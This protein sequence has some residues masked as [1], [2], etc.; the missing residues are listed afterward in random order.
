MAL[1]LNVTP[2]FD[3]FDVNK[4]YLKILFKPGNSVQAREMTQLQSILQGQISNLSDH[5]FKEG[6]MVIPGQAALDLKANYAKVSLNGTLSTANGFVGKIVQGKSTGIRALVVNYSDEVDLNND[7]VIDGDNDE[8]TTLYLKYLDGTTSG[9]T[10]FSDGTTVNIL[11]G[12]TASFTVNGETV[13]ISEGQTSTF[14]EGEEL[15]ATTTD[16]VNLVCTV[17]TSSTVQNPIGIGSQ[18]FIEEGV[19]YINGNLVRVTSQSLILDKYSNT[20]SYKIGLEISESVVNYNDDPSLLDNSLG[21][22]NYNSPGADRYKVQLTLAKRDYDAIDTTNFVELIAVRNGFVS[23]YVSSTDYSVLMKTL[24]RRTYDE[25]G[26]YTVRPF[27]LDIREYFKENN[28][29][30]VYT[31]SDLVFETEVAAKDFALQNFPDDLGMVV[32]GEGQAHTISTID[33]TTYAEQT[34]DN[35][36]L[37]YYPGQTHENLLD[38]IRDKLAVGV[39]A[40]KAYV[41]GYE[42]ERKPSSNQSK[43][44]IFDKSRNNYQINNKYMPVNLGA[45]I[46]VTDTKGLFKIDESVNLVNVHSSQSGSNQ[47][48]NIDSNI[49][50]GEADYLHTITYNPTSVFFQGGGTTLGTNIYG[51]DV[52]ATAKVKAV[53]YFSESSDSARLNNYLQSN[54]RPTD[55]IEQSKESAIYK[56][57]LYDIEYELNPRTTQPYMMIDARSIVSETTVSNS[58]SDIYENAGNILTQLELTEAQG[59][60]TPKSLI[61]DRY[62]VNFRGINY[63]HN[64]ITNT[65]LIKPLNSGNIDAGA[66]GSG[67]LPSAS[68]T[69]NELIS[70]AIPS[71][72]TS[73]TNAASWNNSQTAD[74]GNVLARIF[75][76]SVLHNTS[77]SSLVDTGK[78]WVRTARNIN[79]LTGVSSIDTQYSVMKQ[80]NSV[81]FPAGTV[82]LIATEADTYFENIPSLYSIFSSAN[83]SDTSGLVGYIQNLAFSADLR[84]V[85]FDVTGT[86][87]ITSGFTALVPMKK[88]NAKEKTKTL[89]KNYI[90]LPL[91]LVGIEGSAINSANYDNTIGAVNETTS[92]YEADVLGINS[93]ASTGTVNPSF[94]V[95]ASGDVSM[96]LSNLQLQNADVRELIKLY[97][98]CNV[99]NV[100]YRTGVVSDNKKFIHEMTTADFDFAFKAYEFYEQ[101]GQS[102]FNVNL[103]NSVTTS[104]TELAV[105][106]VVDGIENPFNTEIINAWTNGNLITN[107]TEVPVKLNDIT[108]RYDLFDGQKPSIIQLG[109]LD[110]KPGSLPCG[111]RPIAIYSYYNHGVGDYA[112]V[113][114]YVDGYASI[115]YYGSERLSDV[116]DFR[117]VV[118]YVQTTGYP[119]GRGMV[120]SATDYPIDGTAVSADL[121][122]YLARKDKLFMDKLGRVRLKYGSPAENPSMPED[123]SEGMVL[124]ELESDP[125]TVGPKAIAT[126][127]RDNKRYTMRD[128][129]NLEKRI[130]NLE[131]Y[132]SLN[133]LEKDTMDLAVRDE[134]GNDRFKNGFIV[135]R[136]VDHTV[137]NVFD[138]DYKVSI[139]KTE[140]V[141]RSFFSEKLVNMTLDARSS[142][143]YAIKEQKIHLPYTSEYL[144][145]QEKSSKTV[146]VNPFAIFTFRGSISMF[147]STDEWKET[148][149]TPDIVT[150]RREQYDNIFGALS[151]EDG[152]MG[153]MWNGWEENW[154]GRDDSSTSSSRRAN[155][156]NATA[157]IFTPIVASAGLVRQETTTITTTTLTGQKTRTGTEQLVSMR[158][159]RESVGTRTVSTEIIPFIRARDVYFSGEKLKPN[160]KLYQYFDGVNVSDF[161][162]TTVKLTTT[163]TPAATATWRREN[164]SL[165]RD[166]LGQVFIR[167]GSTNTEA[168]IYDINYL[169]ARSLRLHLQTDADSLGFSEGETIF[170]VYPDPDQGTGERSRNIGTWKASGIVSGSDSIISDSSGF[171]SGI[172]SIPNSDNIKFKTGER[173]F[174][175]SDQRNN[176]QD[177]DTEAQTTY[178]ASGTIETVADQIILTR[179]PDFSTRE[180][181]DSE[182]ITDTNIN[183]TVTA[184]GWYDPLAQ[185]IMINQDGG[186][187]ITAVELFFST[188]D[189]T[190][191]VTV[192][193]RQTVNGYPGPKILGQSIVYP[194]NAAV[195]DDGTLPTSFVF[196]SPIYVQD[197]TEYCIVIMAD[198]QG[199]RCHV[200]RMGEDSLDGSGKISQQPYAGVFFKSQNASTWTADQMEDLKF[201]VSRAKFDTNTQAEIYLQNNE[202][203]DNG[204]DLWAE[205]LNRNSLKVFNGDTKVT[206]SISDSGGMVATKFWQSNGYNYVTLKNFFGTYGVFPSESFNGTH[207]VTDTTYNSFTIDL[208]NPFYP[209]GSSTS[210]VAYNGSVLPTTDDL[211]SPKSNTASPPTVSSNFKYDLIKPIIQN[212]ELPKTSMTFGMRGLSGTSQDSTQ[213][214]GIKDPI[215]SGFIPNTNYEL[216]SPKMVATYFNENEFNTDSSPIDK[217]SL[218]FRVGMRTEVDNLSPIIDTQRMSAILISNQTNSPANV[219]DGVI[220]HVNTGFVDE[221][222]AAGGSVATKYMTR[223]VTLDQPATSL[224][225]LASVNR[226]DGCDVDFYYRV[227]TSE[228]QLFSKLSYT[229]MSRPAA[230]NIASTGTEDYKEFDFDLRGLSEFTSVSIKIVLKTNNSSIV[231]KVKDFRVIA[232]AS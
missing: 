215:Y 7:D 15:V 179:L 169:A 55:D 85:S 109:E 186:C 204:N 130:E 80:F 167:G 208:R 168:R 3:D 44:V 173:I 156:S 149:Q 165:V 229:L 132:T 137:G 116:L 63:Y 23:N 111:G 152:V 62:N 110:L 104:L 139:S 71:T 127:M 124:Y 54:Y 4:G 214:P 213:V 103:D 131:Y 184:G 67:V 37:L 102:P 42:I 114:S 52:I 134:N 27:K 5:F 164:P 106:L 180:V 227:K 166:N 171:V 120:S 231:P 210:Q 144:I 119:F 39:E 178:V 148:K 158:D 201:R 188:K 174:K 108:D 175:M 205:K 90:E 189:A 47:F 32:N 194:E 190:K 232:L 46:Y 105:L 209:I 191:P 26:D 125:Y 202:R 113:D 146:N 20:P 66:E 21:T 170:I 79:E 203:D 50:S 117:P 35:T 133:M 73:T 48:I 29:G 142:S 11:D 17:Q 30:G 141:L 195:S 69:T 161:C 147:P 53:E 218:V 140:G 107:P 13:T 224:R 64:N 118:S 28:N 200:A 12:G 87:A 221:T 128:I 6:A 183:T 91:S 216:T 185:T 51:T 135:D 150:D 58:G 151:P 40:G 172:F 219:A 136:F 76:K 65:M 77:G 198:T 92:S 155:R 211:F 34:L 89:V 16:G 143:G 93:S 75:S 81:S 9:S 98:T 223:E 160:T 86:G 101:T 14:V 100:A 24:A 78:K 56:V 33:L 182:A 230:Y 18:A 153:T 61:F 225:V 8:F 88:T 99:N 96:S 177:T 95:G 199:Y 192:Q 10:T 226:Q 217:K 121:R 176:S 122:V 207:L 187:F 49:D 36:G 70:E 193:L 138:P 206:F 38:A 159:D 84:T 60:F 163:D 41:R 115:G 2:Y 97:D 154:T 112:S 129:G 83:S 43:Y 59:G 31:M 57:Y 45:F 162:K 123:P 72:D 19:Y 82:T 181:S 1:N 157:S 126:K 196:P 212:I 197:E 228:D 25:S 220:G 74:N 94:A 222:S 145:T 68:F 22:T